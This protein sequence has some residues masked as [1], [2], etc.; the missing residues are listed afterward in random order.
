[1][2]IVNL[3]GCKNAKFHKNKFGGSADLFKLFFANFSVEK[4]AVEIS[5]NIMI[6]KKFDSKKICWQALKSKFAIEKVF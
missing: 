6:I 4:W 2:L 1:L 3:C 5:V